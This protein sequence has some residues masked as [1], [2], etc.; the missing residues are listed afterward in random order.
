MIKYNGFLSKLTEILH[1]LIIQHH[2]SHSTSRRYAR[3]VCTQLTGP[4]IETSKIVIH[5][6]IHALAPPFVRFNTISCFQSTT[7]WLYTHYHGLYTFFIHVEGGADR[8]TPK[9]LMSPYLVMSALLYSPA[10]RRAK[11][12]H[13]AG[14]VYLSSYT[15]LQHLFGLP[16][17]LA[18]CL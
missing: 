15:Y 5:K 17:H 18:G 2:E 4:Y 10:G 9:H 11:K 6:F 1:Q 12:G 8:I 13:Y 14:R 7:V 3:C 16:R